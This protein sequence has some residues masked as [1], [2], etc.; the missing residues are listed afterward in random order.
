M[1]DRPDYAA[2]REGMPV[3]D[4]YDRKIGTVVAVIAPSE[5]RVGLAEGVIAPAPAPPGVVRISTGI[6]GLGADRYVPFSAIR[7]I[8]D[9]AVYLSITKADL[10]RLETDEGS[11]AP[12]DRR[13]A[14]QQ[15]VDGPPSLP[16][17]SRRGPPGDAL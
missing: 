11:L 12:V 16:R 17:W 2:L 7:A 13:P 8:R 1:L 4:F 9:A 10:D 15:P 5:Q 3:Y 14:G 6:F